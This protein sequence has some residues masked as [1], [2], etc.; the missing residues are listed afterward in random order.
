[1]E[2][3]SLSIAAIAEAQVIGDEL[4]TIIAKSHGKESSRTVHTR[5]AFLKGLDEGFARVL[6]IV[7]LRRRS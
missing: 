3:E 6:E 5:A 2:R 7:V 1:M 4:V